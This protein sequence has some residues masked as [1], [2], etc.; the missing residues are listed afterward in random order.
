MYKVLLL[1]SIQKK[2]KCYTV[3]KINKLNFTIIELIFY[4]IY[5]YKLSRPA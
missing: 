4:D 5:I 1:H 2:K 3:N